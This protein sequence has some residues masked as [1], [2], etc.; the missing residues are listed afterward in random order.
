MI[1]DFSSIDLNTILSIAIPAIVAGVGGYYAGVKNWWN[2]KSTEE[3]DDTVDDAANILSDGKV[4]V[5]E[6]T[7]FVKEHVIKK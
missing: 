7:G 5:S 4:T 1:F 2:S 6:A 3:K